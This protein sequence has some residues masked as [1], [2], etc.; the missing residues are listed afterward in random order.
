MGQVPLP[1]SKPLCRQMKRDEGSEKGSGSTPPP[2]HSLT[3]RS[4]GR[5][6]G[7]VKKMQMGMGCWAQQWEP[8]LLDQPTEHNKCRTLWWGSWLLTAVYSG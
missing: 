3:R 5:R 4:Q 1:E 8:K 2:L 7:M 6:T